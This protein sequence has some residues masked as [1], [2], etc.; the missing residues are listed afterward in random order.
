MDLSD[1]P[2][3]TPIIMQSLHTQKNLQNPPGS[4]IARCVTDNRDMYEHVI[5]HRV[6]DDK[7]AIQSRRN[8]HF[9]RV[10]PSGIC[11]FVLT[12]IAYW[13]L[14]TMETNAE[15]SLHIVSH[16][17]GKVL[18]CADNGVV[19][20]AKHNGGDRVAWRIVEPRTS[21]TI[22]PIQEHALNSRYALVDK[23]RQNF[24]MELTKN[25]KTPDEIEQIVTRLFD[26]PADVSA[27]SSTA[28]VPAAKK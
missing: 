22:T 17:T 23:D 4:K 1:I 12:E 5:L 24:V 7:V 14:F 16:Y 3:N 20:C 9:L 11:M 28:A 27:S 26:G 15:C 19:E 13:D 21:A 6:R 2:F 8:V 10:R 25:G 18:Q